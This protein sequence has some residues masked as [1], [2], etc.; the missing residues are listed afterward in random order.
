MIRSIH[1]WSEEMYFCESQSLLANN[2]SSIIGI[3]Q[4]RD[5]NLV[6]FYYVAY[7]IDNSYLSKL[8]YINIK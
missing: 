6:V 7:L 5:D 3:Q 4:A 8:L 1:E 2:K